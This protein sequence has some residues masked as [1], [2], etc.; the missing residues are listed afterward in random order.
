MRKF[1][2]CFALIILISFTLNC[3]KKENEVPKIRGIMGVFD[4]GISQSNKVVLDS[5]CIK[6]LSQKI[7]DNIYEQRKISQP[8]ITE[9]RFA[10]YKNEA[11]VSFLLKDKKDDTITELP[12]KLFLKKKWGK[13][14]VENFE[15]E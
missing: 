2:L 4:R 15:I 14:K 10:I 11:E 7:L 1:I 3:F 13:W 6:G 12:V 8:Q 9:R 5:V